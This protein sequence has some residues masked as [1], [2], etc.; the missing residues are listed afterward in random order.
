[1]HFD[2]V[3]NVSAECGELNSTVSKGTL[4]FGI[5]LMGLEGFFAGKTLEKTRPSVEEGE[6]VVEENIY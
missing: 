1:M 5:T 2:S 6:V 4:H 3:R